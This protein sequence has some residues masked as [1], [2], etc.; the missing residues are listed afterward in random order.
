MGPHLG[1]TR[2]HLGAMGPHLG[3]TR[4]HLGVTRPHLGAMGPHLGATRRPQVRTRRPLRIFSLC[5]FYV[6]CFIF[7]FQRVEYQ[8]L[9][10]MKHSTR[11]FHIMFQ[12]F[13]SKTLWGRF[14]NTVGAI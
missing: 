6:S 3:A 4:P 9:R 12:C 5:Y 2:P 7:I 14:K 13:I 10:N 8:S 11:M 1:A